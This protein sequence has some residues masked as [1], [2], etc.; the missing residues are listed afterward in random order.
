MSRQFARDFYLEVKKGNVP[1]HKAIHKFGQN[2]DID[3]GGF[4]DIWNAGGLYTGF[5]AVAADT[6]E[7]FSAAGADA[8]TLVASGTATGGSET[9]IVDT[10]ATFIT[11]GVAVGDIVLNDT[12]VW[13][14]IVK[15][16]TSETTLTV[17]QMQA[18]TPAQV[19]D[20]EGNES[21]D[22][23]RV[24]TTASTGVAVVRAELALDGDYNEISEYVIMNGV[25]AVASTNTVLRCSRVKSVL[26]GSGG[27]N[28]GDVT[29]WQQTDNTIVW[30][31]MPAGY[32]QT[33]ICAYTIPAGKSAYIVH[34]YASLAKKQTAFSNVR[35][36]FKM[37]GEPIRVQEEYTLVSTGTSKD[38]RPYDIPKDTIPERTDIVI[39]ADSS[40]NDGSVS[41]GFDLILVDN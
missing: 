16:V 28:A 41:A 7:F 40:V 24:A 25:T 23:Y 26:A 8:G 11:A 29:V 4:E 36:M 20:N 19:R 5:N 14:G 12:E 9:T 13:H 39:R 17:W 37:V 33:T 1:G 27:T 18:R 38:E 6:A 22:A 2:P 15:A 3:T 30:V 32:G 10:G 34:W 35:L 31:D 21:G